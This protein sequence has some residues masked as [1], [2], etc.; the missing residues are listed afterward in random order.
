MYKLNGEKMF[1][2]VSD[3]QA[4]VINYVTGMYYGTGDLGSVILERLVAGNATDEILE[5]VKK[6]PGCPDDIDQRLAD[7]I[8]V[9]VKAEILIPGETMPGGGEVISESVA[10]NGFDLTLDE[11]AEVQDL[12]LAD[13]IHDVD[14]EMGWP[15]FDKGADNT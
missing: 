2:D 8:D 6:L 3:G 4:V 13:P 15:I 5:S 7:F 14:V 11:F 12:L 1:F 9:L 10:E